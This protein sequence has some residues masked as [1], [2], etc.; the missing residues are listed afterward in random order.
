MN[1]TSKGTVPVER[2]RSEVGTLIDPSSG[3]YNKIGVFENSLRILPK[4]VE[5]PEP[6]YKL[7]L[8]YELNR[9]MNR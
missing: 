6:L 5:R 7:K 2:Y 3:K 9:E 1:L 4:I 8:V